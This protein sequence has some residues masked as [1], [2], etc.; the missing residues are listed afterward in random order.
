MTIAEEST[1][2]P[3]V[4]RPTNFGGLGFGF[5][6]NMGWMHDTLDYMSRDP[7]YRRWSHHKITFG[8][9]YAFTENF[10][11]PFSHDEVVYGKGS[12]IGKMPGDEWQNFANTRAYYGLMW[13]HPGKKLLF[14]GQEFGQTSEWNSNSAA[15]VAARP[16]AAPG[17][18]GAGRDLNRLISLTPGCLRAT[19]RP[20]GSAGSSST[21]KTSRCSLP[22]SGA[23]RLAGRGDQQLHARGPTRYRIGLP[24]SGHWT[25]ALNTDSAITGAPTSATW[26]PSSRNGGR[27]TALRPRRR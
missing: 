23:E 13:G 5:K 18:A 12:V 8:L 21:T 2:F 9:L 24:S 22:R 6:W 15:L 25:E 16:L 14:M 20:R 3:G 1:A 10:V 27:C 11:L 26:A 17:L 19:A 7:V 4:S